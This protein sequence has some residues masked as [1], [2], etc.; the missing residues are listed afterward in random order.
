MP[1]DECISCGQAELQ[2]K[3]VELTGEV[4]GETFT[5]EMPGLECPACGYKTIEGPD[6]A[7]Y[8]RLLADKYR[9][10]HGLLTSEEI[11]S[12]RNKL[13]ISQEEFAHYVGVGVASI[14]RWEWGR[15]QDEQSNTKLVD[16]THPVYNLTC[17]G[18]TYSGSTASTVSQGLSA[19]G[20]IGTFGELLYVDLV[21]ET[22]PPTPE[23]YC[24]TAA[25]SRRTVPDSFTYANTVM[26]WMLPR[27]S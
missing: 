24:M 27:A 4:R 12:R 6:S 26:P 8:E 5:V 13:G 9:A 7:E 17:V 20:D 3:T 18:W 23:M 2:Y 19:I 10:A 22:E 14:K 21:R 15:I 1:T 25:R 16:A 11:R